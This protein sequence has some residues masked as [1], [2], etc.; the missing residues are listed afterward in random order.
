MTDVAQD[1]LKAIE[2]RL[3]VF[4]LETGDPKWSSYALDRF[5]EE[6]AAAPNGSVEDIYQG[7]D[8]ALQA[9]SVEL[10]KPVAEFIKELVVGCFTRHRESYEAISWRD[11]VD[12]LDDQATAARL[13][14]ALLAIPA[15][16]VTPRLAD[17]IAK[18]LESTPFRDE[19]AR[20]FA[21]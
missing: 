9:N 21:A 12:S 19:A 6:A 15:R 10:T 5:V 16:H 11:T 7:L 14:L 13:Y 2:S 18:G 8:A 4:Q 3:K 20:A 17:A 1:R